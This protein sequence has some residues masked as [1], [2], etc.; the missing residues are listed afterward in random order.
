[1]AMVST[2]YRTL[3]GNLMLEVEPTG[4]R[5]VR[6]AIIEVTESNVA[7]AGATSETFT[8]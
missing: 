7:V 8:R 2:V 3:I 4:Q 1:M 6:T 5:A